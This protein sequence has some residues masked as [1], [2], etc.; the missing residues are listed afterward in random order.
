MFSKNKSREFSTNQSYFQ[1]ML[2]HKNVGYAGW[3]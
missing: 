2:H 3:F 1:P